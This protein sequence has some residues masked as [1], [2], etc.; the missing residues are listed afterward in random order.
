MEAEEGSDDRSLWT[1]RLCRGRL[2]TTSGASSRKTGP[3]LL[4]PHHRPHDR[5]LK[6]LREVDPI[7]RLRPFRTGEPIERLKTI[8]A[9]P[10][11]EIER[12]LTVSQ[13]RKLLDPT[14]HLPVLGGRSRD[15]RYRRYSDL[16]VELSAKRARRR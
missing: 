10:S 13:R 6:D 14:D 1:S 8:A 2:W 15:R 5:A 3:L 4:R 12:A 9:G 11:L 16:M 7:H